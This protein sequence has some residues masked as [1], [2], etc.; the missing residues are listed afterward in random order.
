[1]PQNA[2]HIVARKAAAPQQNATIWEEIFSSDEN[3]RQV[4]DLYS[5]KLCLI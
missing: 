1:M 3:H 2:F 5:D 4:L